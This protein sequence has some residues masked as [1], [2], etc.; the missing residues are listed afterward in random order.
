MTASDSDAG[1]RPIDAQLVALLH[2]ELHG[3][4]RR[5]VLAQLRSDPA[6][7]ARYAALQATDELLGVALE[8]DAAPRPQG[9]SM[10]SRGLVQ[11]LLALA[12]VLT[13]VA[14][15]VLQ[16]PEPEAESKPAGNEHFELRIAPAHGAEAPLFTDAELAL[17]WQNKSAADPRRPLRI[18]PFPFGKTKA[19]IADEVDRFTHIGS[20]RMAVLPV[21]LV[22]RITPPEGEPFEARWAPEHGRHLDV[23]TKAQKQ[24]V[25]LLE[26]E[27][28]L[29]GLRPYLVG[30][31]E[32]DHW[33]DDSRWRF[34]HLGKGSAGRWFPEVPGGYRIELRIES[35]PAPDYMPWP[36]WE[37]DPVATSAIVMGG[38]MT[39]WG[40]E[41]DGMRARLVWSAG[42]ADADTTPFAVQL[43]NVSDRARKYNV[44][45]TTIAEI[46]QP[47]HCTLLVDGAEWQQRERIPL[48]IP[49]SELFAPH[50]AGTIRSIVMRPEYWRSDGRELGTF[51]GARPV[52]ILFHFKPSV[53]V[54]GDK[55]LWMGKLLTPELEIDV[56][57]PK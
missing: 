50:P 28:P 10:L 51:P 35:L 55:E 22:A 33:G 45:G 37:D 41:H 19:A 9:T 7:R 13:V 18:L 16:D 2:G 56:P 1:R 17:F 53:W 49:A 5:A 31:P 27:V 32:R 15:I 39:D 43:Q 46:P 52:R 25:K 14:V 40:E 8:R 23:S 42:C 30:N 21:V 47:L 26:F 6:A 34:Q 29:S 36:T 48:M 12:A 20:L 44:A 54:G 11:P 38:R 3:D 57:E 24:I 4:E